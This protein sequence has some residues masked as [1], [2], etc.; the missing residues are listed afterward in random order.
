[1]TEQEFTALYQKNLDKV[2][3]FIYFKVDSP[4]TAQDLTS[5]V[6]LKFWQN[7]Q[8]VKNP[9]AF[10]FQT[11]R[12]QVIDFYRQKDKTPVSLE[13]LQEQGQEIPQPSFAVQIELSFEL[14]NLKKALRRIKNEYSEVIIWYYLDDLSVK[15]IAEILNKRENNVRVLLHR[16]LETLKKE[17]NEKNS[18]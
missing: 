7:N 9:Q 4:E 10:L 17:V 11:A 16:A 8:P 15:E 18:V 14:E 6:F 3:R 5:Q 12:N 2:F 13:E 1:M